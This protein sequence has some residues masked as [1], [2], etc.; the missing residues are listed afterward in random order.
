MTT[1]PLTINGQ[2]YQRKWAPIYY[3]HTLLKTPLHLDGICNTLVDMVV[4]V[5]PF[6]LFI[7]QLYTVRKAGNSDHIASAQNEFT[8][9][10]DYTRIC[11]FENFL[12]VALEKKICRLPRTILLLESVI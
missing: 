2:G 7:I 6:G 3:S 4:S 9:S 12:S 5:F 8:S 11:A 1:E 10:E